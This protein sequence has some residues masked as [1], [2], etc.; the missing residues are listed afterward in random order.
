MV[1]PLPLITLE[2]TT[3]RLEPLSREHTE[4]L[5]IACSGP[6]DTYQ[7]TWVPEPTISDVERYIGVAQIGRAHV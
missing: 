1:S 6:R 7:F 2:G 5:L 4:E 3:V